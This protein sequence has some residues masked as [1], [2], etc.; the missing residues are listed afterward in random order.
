MPNSASGT[1]DRR[2]GSNT[3]CKASVGKPAL[4]SWISNWIAQS[5]L[6]PDGKDRAL[7]EIRLASG[8]VSNSP[9]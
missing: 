4:S 3:E 7:T 2:R 9:P 1:V 8:A 6:S 5:D